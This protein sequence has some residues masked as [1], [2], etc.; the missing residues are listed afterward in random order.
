MVSIDYRLEYEVTREEIFEM[1]KSMGY[2]HLRTKKRAV[3]KGE[4]W[5]TAE[6]HIK[7][8]KEGRVHIFVEFSTKSSGTEAYPQIDVHAHYDY[9]KKEGKKEFHITRRDMIKDLG[10]MFEIHDTLKQNGYGYMEYKSLNSA[11]DTIKTKKKIQF[12][13]VLIKDGYRYDADGKYK[14][15][16]FEGQIT[17]QII[18][19]HFF[20]HTV[21]VYAIGEKHDLSRE[22]A[23]QESD[24]IMKKLAI[25]TKKIESSIKEKEGLQKSLLLIKSERDNLN[26]KTQENIALIKAKEALI[27]KEQNW[28]KKKNLINEKGKIEKKLIINKKLADQKH[29]KYLE[30]RKQSVGLKKKIKYLKKKK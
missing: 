25:Y 29:T 1:F 19:Q 24:R 18:E 11:H 30:V 4:K 27:V 8:T 13:H 22:K 3:K 14:K 20:S 10:E 17:F 21:C 6:E 5:I 28:K 12:E 2:I 23:L 9:V 26:K 7:V 16:I 15:R